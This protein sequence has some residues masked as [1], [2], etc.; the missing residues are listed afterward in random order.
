[1]SGIEGFIDKIQKD[2]DKN[3]SKLETIIDDKG[4]NSKEAKKIEKKIDKKKQTLGEY[5]EQQ[6]LEIAKSVS[7]KESKKKKGKGR[8]RIKVVT[9][10]GTTGVSTGARCY[11]RYG[12]A[13]QLYRICKGPPPPTKKPPAVFVPKLTPSAF[14]AKLMKGN[15]SIKG[16]GDLSSSQK[17]NYHRL[18]M[19]QTRESMRENQ[20]L[21][22]D[23]YK[24]FLAQKRADL[25][26]D[27]AEDKIQKQLAQEEKSIKNKVERRGP[28]AANPEEI[29]KY[30]DKLKEKRFKLETGET[31]KEN[32]FDDKEEK[33]KKN[34]AK[35][36]K[37]SD[38]DKKRLQIEALRKELVS[39]PK[40]ELKKVAGGEAY[41]RTGDI[42][43]IYRTSKIR[44]TNKL[45]G[46]IEDVFD[47]LG[48]PENVGLPRI[49]RNKNQLISELERY[50]K[51]LTRDNK[52]QLQG[53]EPTPEQIRKN[54]PPAFKSLEPTEEK[55]LIDNYDKET[56]KI[57]K[58]Q[59]EF[60]R[61]EYDKKI[62][63]L[64]KDLTETY[65][66]K[67]QK[68]IYKY[69][70]AVKDAE[71]KGLGPKLVR[72]N[73]RVVFDGE[74]VKEFG[75]IKDLYK[76][77]DTL[78]KV[79]E[80]QDDLSKIT[81]KKKKSKKKTKAEINTELLNKQLAKLEKLKKL[82]DKLSKN[83]K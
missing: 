63:G 29:K 67:A 53:R 4:E 36:E 7:K 74:N 5:Q 14:V 25:K 18:A 45:K 22:H 48:I 28:T 59:M 68:A 23:E 35:R 37:R 75:N 15:K 52:K 19:A 76:L 55:M 33:I 3:E 31:F 44:L 6:E 16:Y 77:K 41:K 72:K 17:Q 27:R 38:K 11:M 46:S 78:D 66:T 42:D 10:S 26:L 12:N 83:K 56:E 47:F 71:A 40:F 51:G 49:E 8:K 2:I 80:L 39:K 81:E 43:G 20:A 70:Q 65:D 58:E 62:K 57:A 50:V 69:K 32:F 13:G 61:K 54:L 21:N 82:A 34:V 73:V 60:F 64:R 9:K 24:V 30:F 79:D 1:M